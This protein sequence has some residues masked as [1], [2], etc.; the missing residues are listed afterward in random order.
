MNG[1]GQTTDRASQGVW[2]IVLHDDGVFH[3]A[4][5]QTQQVLLVADTGNGLV[6]E[7]EVLLKEKINNA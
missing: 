7:Q 1:A 4:H 5:G 2:T 6:K 3:R